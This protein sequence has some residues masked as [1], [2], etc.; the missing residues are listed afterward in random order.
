MKILLMILLC[1]FTFVFIETAMA[2]AVLPIASPVA[3]VVAV[4][5]AAPVSVG[6]LSF[7]K[8]NLAVIA[9]AIYFLIDIVILL[10]PNLAANGLLHQV[11]LW[12]GKESGQVPPA[13][14]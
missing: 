6:L 3:P 8:S 14:S 5:A 2:Q 7:V 10:S 1:A 11:Q 4:V 12:L 13:S 9:G